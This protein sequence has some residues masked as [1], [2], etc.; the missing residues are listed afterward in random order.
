VI[1]EA[2]LVEVL[3]REE[4]VDRHRAHLEGGAP[5][6]RHACDDPAGPLGEERPDLAQHGFEIGAFLFEGGEALTT[7]GRVLLDV[8]RPVRA[9]GPEGPDDA[10]R[11]QGAERAMPTCEPFDEVRE[12]EA[13]EQD[14]AELKGGLKP[15]KV[16]IRGNA[17]KK[18]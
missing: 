1:E 10:E 2:G 16:K 5:R 12:P 17:G 15:V 8:A 9:D 14:G 7:P 11:A 6:G 18:E 4:G 13:G 3:P